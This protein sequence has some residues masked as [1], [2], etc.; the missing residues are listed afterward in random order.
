MFMSFKCS[1]NFHRVQNILIHRLS[2]TVNI[3]SRL[4]NQSMYGREIEREKHVHVNLI[5][6]PNIADGMD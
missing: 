2:S 5:F 3:W 6:S 4:M 1:I